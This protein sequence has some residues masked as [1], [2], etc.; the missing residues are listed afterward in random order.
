MKKYKWKDAKL[1][2]RNQLFNWISLGLGAVALMMLYRLSE[3][4]KVWNLIPLTGA[5]LSWFIAY[6][7]RKDDAKGGLSKTNK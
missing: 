6:Q 5:V 1:Q 3:A 7:A 4:Y 2:K